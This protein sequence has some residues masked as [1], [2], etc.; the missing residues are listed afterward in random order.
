MADRIFQIVY[1]S[2]ATAFLDETEADTLARTAGRNNAA[3]AVTG[4]LLHDGARFIQALEG[5]E[6][7]VSE[8]MDRIARDPRHDAITYIHRGFADTRQFGTWSMDMRRVHDS[9]S[10]ETFVDEVKEAVS[11][12]DDANLLAAFI[13][14]AVMG[15][16]TRG[17]PEAG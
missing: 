4:L 10:A 15:R 6:T 3:R 14:F 12:V 1:I 9:A 5:S 17:E 11:S 16:R 7:G 13:G 2:R 8:V